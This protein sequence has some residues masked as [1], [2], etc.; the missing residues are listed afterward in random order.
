MPTDP[1]ALMM[2]LQAL[3]QA[4]GYKQVQQMKA[5]TP[6]QGEGDEIRGMTQSLG[7]MPPAIMADKALI[8][9]KRKYGKAAF[10]AAW[11][12]NLISYQQRPQNVPEDVWAQMVTSAGS[13]PMDRDM[14]RYFSLNGQLFALAGPA[15]LKQSG[16]RAY[17]MLKTL[18]PHVPDYNMPPEL[19]LERAQDLYPRIKSTYKMY[20]NDPTYGAWTKAMAPGTIKAAHVQWRKLFSPQ[21][22]NDYGIGIYRNTDMPMGTVRVYQP[23]GGYLDLSTGRFKPDPAPAPLSNIP[24]MKARGVVDRLGLGPT[25][26][27]PS[28]MPTPGMASDPTFGGV[29]G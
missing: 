10:D 12:R 23:K 4:E 15:L 13:G 27:I 20:E 16:S 24:L 8:M 6:T 28:A 19:A 14:R 26:V 17:Q 3:K 2:R 29:G 1:I 21:E 9:D 22:I 5:M 11:R 7:M 25:K 18:D